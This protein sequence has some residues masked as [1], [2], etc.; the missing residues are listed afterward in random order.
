MSHRLLALTLALGL[1]GPGV[2]A[3]PI[4]GGQPGTLSGGGGGGGGGGGLA[5]ACDGGSSV[6]AGFKDGQTFVTWTDLATGASGAA[7]RYRVYRSTAAITSG[8]YASATLIASYITNNSGQLFGGDPTSGATQGADPFSQSYRQTSTRPMAVLA[9]LGTP[10]AP[11]TGLQA[12]TAKASQNAYY[13]VVSTNTSDASPSY[14]GSVGP[15]AETVATPQAIKWAD[16]LSRGQ[17]YGKITGAANLPLVYKGHQSGANSGCSAVSC[18]WG[19]YW[20]MFLT[21]IEGWVDGRPV[22]FSVSEDVAQHAPSLA[23]SL[24]VIDRDTIWSTDASLGMELYHIGGG[25]TPNPLSGVANRFYLFGRK[26]IERELNWTISHFNADPNQIHWK[27]QSMGAWGGASSGI[28]MTSPH[29]SAMW[30]AYPVWRHDRR[31]CGNWP[32]KTWTSAMPFKATIDVAS[33]TLGCIAAN[34]LMS[35]G[36]TW[37][38]SG[39]YA[40]TPS[41]IAANPGTDLP[42]TAWNI[43]KYDPYPISFLEQIEAVAAFESAYRGYAFVWATMAHEGTAAGEGDINCDATTKDAAVCYSKPLFK[44]NLPYIA[45]GNSSIN[46]NLGTNTPTANGLID[47]DYV[48]CINCGFKWTVSSDTSGAFNFT[49][50]NAWMTRSP[51]TIPLTT[52]TETMASSGSG[53]VA[54]TSSA[55]WQSTGLNPYALVG[56]TEV[57]KISSTVGNVITFSSRGLFGTTAA[58]HSAGQTITQFISQPTGPNGGPYATMTADVTPRRRQNFLPANGSTVT[59][60][61]TPFGAGSTVQTPTVANGLFTLTGVT[62]NAGGVTTATCN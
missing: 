6:C 26:Q 20:E 5:E 22:A 18:Q 16:S 30:L 39:G 13:A 59:C 52:L 37:G 62:I 28:R 61:I 50:S 1:Y 2:A 36:T 38:G 7:Y 4:H 8:N 33:Q 17:S 23:R 15:I 48:G 32:G 34:V 46:D 56:G 21:T 10:L 9:D 55:G 31:A 3:G 54:V 42:F 58:A 35:D 53:T 45:F 60:T 47:G 57:V 19:D 24:E 41:F 29:I 49:V 40:D 43:G 11:Y 27:G 14:I 25:F 44:L 12:Y 51:T